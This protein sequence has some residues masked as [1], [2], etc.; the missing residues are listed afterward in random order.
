MVRGVART[1]AIEYSCEDTY[2]LLDEF[3]EAVVQGKDVATLMPLVQQ[4]LEMCPDCR[5]EFEALLRVV[6][7]TQP[8]A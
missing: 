7:A 4:H 5:E 8:G 3:T 6:R 2:R 1:Q